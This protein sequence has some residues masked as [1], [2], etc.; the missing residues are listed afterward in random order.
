MEDEIDQRRIQIDSGYC[1]IEKL[2]TLE[3]LPASV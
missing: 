2:S 1:H 3:A